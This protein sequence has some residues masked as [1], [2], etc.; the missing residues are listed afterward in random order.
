MI[1]PIERLPEPKRG[2]PKV[3]D[4]CR[5]GRRGGF[6][7]VEILIVIGLL[8][9]LA[10]IVLVSGGSLLTSTRVKGTRATI[11]ALRLKIDEYQSLTGYAPPDGIDTPVKNS[12]GTAV[13]GNAALHHALTSPITVRVMT[14]GIPR[15]KT[16]EPRKSFKD[17]EV[18]AEDPD[19]PGVREIVDAFGVPFHYD[20]T[21]DGRMRPQDGGVHYPPVDE[22][23]HP[24]DPRTGED[25]RLDLGYD[26]W[27]HGEKE[28][29]TEESSP[30]IGTWNVQ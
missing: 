29:S 14:G 12:S 1:L 22:E 26:L 19:Y 8:V 2:G 9:F 21:E 27:S 16:Y 5:R 18:T 28:H 7:L 11:E 4:P 24:L 17:S 3:S 10:S 6:T 20:N 23:E 30:P 15:Q 25:Y 13:R